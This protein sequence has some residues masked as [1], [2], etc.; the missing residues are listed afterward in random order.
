MVGFNGGS[1]LAITGVDENGLAHVQKVSRILVNTLLAGC[2]GGTFATLASAFYNFA[3]ER[4]KS[5]KAGGRLEAVGM[6]FKEK[7]KR[8]TI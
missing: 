3:V 7:E 6:E 2:A 8:N 1:E 4:N 5:L